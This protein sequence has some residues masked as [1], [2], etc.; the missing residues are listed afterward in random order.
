MAGNFKIVV[1]GCGGIS[2][3]WFKALQTAE[4][5]KNNETFEKSPRRLNALIFSYEKM[6]PYL[7]SFVFRQ[8]LK[9][10]TEEFREAQQF[11]DQLKVIL[12][13]LMEINKVK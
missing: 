13:E 12:L 3:L 1:V 7:P 10:E 9:F 6:W 8:W 2:D 11:E 4:K 5:K